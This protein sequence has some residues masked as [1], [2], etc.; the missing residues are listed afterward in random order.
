MTCGDIQNSENAMGVMT[1]LKAVSI[2][3]VSQ[4]KFLILDSAGDL[5]VLSL[6]DTVKA[7][8][9]TAPCSVTSKDAHIN[10]LDSTMKVQMLAVLPDISSKIQAVWISDGGY[11]LHM[12][13]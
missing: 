7:P 9:D 13:S 12:I 4:K 6:H 8:E 10:H 2:Q 11:S 3:A 5:H 1:S